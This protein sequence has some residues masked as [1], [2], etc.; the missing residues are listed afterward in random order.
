MANPYT[1]ARAP[2]SAGLSGLD[3]LMPDVALQQQQVARQQALADALRARALSGDD[4]ATQVV[5]GWAI[6][7]GISKPLSRLA[8]ALGANI[9]Q[10]GAD[11]KQQALAEALATKMQE[12]MG[13]L[14]AASGNAGGSGWG[15]PAGAMQEAQLYET[16]GMP[17]MAKAV[18]DQYAPTAEQKNARM[19]GLTPEEFG[20]AI[21]AKSAK[22]GTLT[23]SP[24]ETVRTPDGKTEVIPMSPYQAQSLEVDKQRADAA[25]S[26]ARSAAITAGGAGG[27]AGTGIDAQAMNIYSTLTLKKNSGQQLTPQ[28]SMMLDLAT[29][30]LMQPRVVGTAEGGMSV[31]NAPPLP[32]PDGA[33]PAAAPAGAVQ[34]QG[35]AGMPGGPTITP[36]TQKQPSEGERKDAGFAARMRQSG[37]L[38]EEIGASGQPTFGTAAVGQIPAVGGVTE[39]LAQSA[40]QQKYRQAQEDWVRAKLRKESGAVIGKEEMDQEIATYFPRPGD[41]PDVV[42][43]KAKQRELATSAMEYAAGKSAIAPLYQQLQM[44]PGSESGAAPNGGGA[45]RKVVKFGDLN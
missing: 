4:T 1:S 10:R 27:F 26:Q 13:A 38:L 28:E 9:A 44:V 36:L 33:A 16:L 41:G 6:P 31:I 2:T 39:R 19:G 14:G 17:G 18:L 30:Q 25:S 11:K 37:A 20:A 24:G 35:A 8:E 22:E 43:Q 21:R 45:P 3:L 29:R 7:N 34:P 15:I 12:R 5:G 42:A 32:T 23:F 40:A